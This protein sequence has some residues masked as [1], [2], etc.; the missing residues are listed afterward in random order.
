MRGC[1]LRS[2]C[3]TFQL[4]FSQGKAKNSFRSPGPEEEPWI[5]D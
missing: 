1:S 5:L 2:W 3:P 4:W